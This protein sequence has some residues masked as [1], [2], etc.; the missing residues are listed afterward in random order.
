[1]DT[2]TQIALGASVGE[3]VVGRQV[4]R[5]AALWGGICGL[6]P[7]LDVLIPLGDAVKEFTYH[8]SASHSLFVLTALTPLLV[9]LILKF[10]PTLAQYRRRWYMLVWLALTTHILLDSFTVYGTQIFWPLKTPPVMWSTIFIID[11]VYTLPL[12]GGLL[13]SL[14][15][16]RQRNRGHL[17]NRAGLILSSL[18]LAWSIGAKLHVTA[19]AHA[20]LQRQGI[21]YTQVLTGP[22]PFNTVLWRILVMDERGYYEGFYS[23]LD[24][25]TQVAFTHYPSHDELLAGIEGHWPVQR[26]QW[27]TQGFYAVHKMNDAVVMTDLRMGLEPT[28]VFNFKV[29]RIGNPHA[30]PVPSERARGIRSLDQLTWVWDRIWAPRPPDHQHSP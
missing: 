6:L 8:R 14:I 18:Y 15:L 26:L 3:A 25:T 11:P 7:D 23:L 21:A 28:Y 17:L 29:G 16:S 12:L 24:Q 19:T 10:S 27:F 20:D 22:T 1:M 9:A 13:A 30:K 5:R 2:I 4:G